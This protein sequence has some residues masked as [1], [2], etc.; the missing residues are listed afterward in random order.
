[1]AN[2][3][4]TLAQQPPRRRG[5]TMALTV[6][7]VVLAA[8]IGTAAWHEAGSK[9]AVA[10]TAASSP[11]AP[12]EA[13]DADGH[14]HPAA[15]QRAALTAQEET[16]AAD[17][18]RIHDGIK[19]GAVKMTFA[20]LAY[21]MNEI[22]RNAVKAR[23]LPLTQAFVDAQ[24]EARKIVPPASL[25]ALH[26]QYLEAIDLYRAASVEMVKVADDG[27]DSHLIEAQSMTQRA[28][29]A[30]LKTGDKLWPGEYK[31]N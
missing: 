18:W 15:P 29:V 23:V 13:M 28:A 10:P 25:S 30:L 26:Q 5:G 8:L 24:A 21:K 22:D 12:V 17:L 6:G 11:A 4:S 27:S 14:P 19:S 9:A 16:Y 31:P 1:M 2:D 20:G 3:A 7:G